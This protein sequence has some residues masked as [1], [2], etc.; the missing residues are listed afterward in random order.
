[1]YR[2]PVHWY[3][4]DLCYNLFIPLLNTYANLSQATVFFPGPFVTI[5]MSGKVSILHVVSHLGKGQEYLSKCMC[6][7]TPLFPYFILF[8]AFASAFH[9]LYALFYFPLHFTSY[10]YVLI[11]QFS[12]FHL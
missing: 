1:M 5:K 4:N 7:S 2:W 12:F 6:P 9:P 11:S 3:F 8:L 10:F